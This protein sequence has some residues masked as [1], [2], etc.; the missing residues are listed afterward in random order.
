MVTGIEVS[1]HKDS[2]GKETTK[3]HRIQPYKIM[4]SKKKFNR[5]SVFLATRSG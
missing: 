4:N 2:F 5:K 3:R 1:L